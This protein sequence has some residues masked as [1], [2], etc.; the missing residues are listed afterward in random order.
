MC[1]LWLCCS[2]LCGVMCLLCSCRMCLRELC[3]L[4]ACVIFII[5]FFICVYGGYYFVCD[6]GK[7]INNCC[8]CCRPAPHES[9]MII[10]IYAAY[11]IQCYQ[12]STSGPSDS[13][14]I[15]SCMSAMCCIMLRYSMG[16]ITSNLTEY[17]THHT[18]HWFV[19]TQ[20]QR[21]GEEHRQR[22]QIII[23]LQLWKFSRLT[24]V[25]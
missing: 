11:R 20:L 18:L 24:I 5:C 6:H 2:C 7:P 10:A 13:T 19:D 22:A 25:C 8:S 12:L 4:F 14:G 15:W 16:V 9:T 17:I 1:V 21:G 23:R 3:L